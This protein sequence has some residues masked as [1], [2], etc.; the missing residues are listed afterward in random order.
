MCARYASGVCL[1]THDT[2]QGSGG[3]GGGG[4]GGGAEGVNPNC[5][6]FNW[7][8][9]CPKRL[10]AQIFSHQQKKMCKGRILRR[11]ETSKVYKDLYGKP[12]KRDWVARVV[13]PI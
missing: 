9:N 3:G 4:G 12:F 10:W 7:N 13:F 6:F 5:I 2:V 11:F 8:T 1:V